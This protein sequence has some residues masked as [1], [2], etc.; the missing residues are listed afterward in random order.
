[1][2]SLSAVFNSTSTLV[3]IDVYK[4]LN[5]GAPEKNLV[6]VGQASTAI[7]VGL[8]LA[9]IPLMKLVSGQLYQYLQSVQAYISPP[10]AAVFLIGILWKRVNANGAIAALIGGFVLGMGR[11]LLELN[12]TSLTGALRAYADINFLHFAVFLFVVCSAILIIVSLF[13]RQP[14]VE[15]VD[16]LTLATAR[17]QEAGAPS[18]TLDVALSVALVASVAALWIF[19]S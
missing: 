12:K 1:M 14:P 2:S 7:M 10:I 13:T 4:K 3:T 5:P 18:R 6:I 16:G 11:L 8:G 17:P 15:K 19:F 9:W